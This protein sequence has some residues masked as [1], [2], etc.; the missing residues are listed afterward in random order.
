MIQVNGHP[1]Y[2]NPTKAILHF[3]LL[4]AFFPCLDSTKLCLIRHWAWSFCVWQV[5]AVMAIAAVVGMTVLLFLSGWAVKLPDH[6][7]KMMSFM[8]I[9]S[10]RPSHRPK[11]SNY[12]CSIYI[13]ISYIIYIHTY[14]VNHGRNGSTE[15]TAKS[16]FFFCISAISPT[17]TPPKVT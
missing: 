5:L 16:C 7:G 4:H 9:L 2:L 13:H 6:L 17:P 12:T 15:R 11:R 10:W 1:G 14:I 3:F 8:Y